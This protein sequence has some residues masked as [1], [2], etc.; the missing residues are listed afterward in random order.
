MTDLDADELRYLLRDSQQ[1]GETAYDGHVDGMAQYTC[2]CAWDGRI[3][4]VQWR[5]PEGVEH[6]RLDPQ[7]VTVAAEEISED[8]ASQLLM[9]IAILTIRH[10]GGW[11][12]LLAHGGASE[13]LAAALNASHELYG[14]AMRA[15]IPVFGQQVTFR[16][17][18][19]YKGLMRAYLAD[20][21]APITEVSYE[22]RVIEIGNSLGV[23]I[24]SRSVQ[25]LQVTKGDSVI[26][27]IR[28]KN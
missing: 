12:A 15:C 7:Y 20:L 11:P 18:E 27:T 13:T 10:E 3:W 16:L 8:A 1:L 5:Y 14:E 21:S 26:V 2:E 19:V 25:S 22:A 9:Q 17:R 28:R 24:D 4:A 6:D 23:R